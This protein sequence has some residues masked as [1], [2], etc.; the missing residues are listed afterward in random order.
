M[1]LYVCGSVY[2]GQKPTRRISSLTLVARLS[3]QCPC[4]LLTGPITFWQFTDYRS[5]YASKIFIFKTGCRLF[6]HPPSNNRGL[7]RSKKHSGNNTVHIHEPRRN[8]LW[9]L[10]AACQGPTHLGLVVMRHKSSSVMFSV[11]GNAM[12][13]VRAVLVMVHRLKIPLQLPQS[14]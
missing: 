12:H 11:E 10:T 13:D 5:Q 3:R 8:S 4:P 9:Q 7:I 14:L 6:Q 1:S 2:W